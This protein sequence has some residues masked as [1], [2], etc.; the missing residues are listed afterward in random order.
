MHS[1]QTF[2]WL[3]P[4]LFALV[5][6]STADAGLIVD[7]DVDASQITPG[8]MVITVQDFTL[9]S[10][11]DSVRLRFTEGE[12]VRVQTSHAG[13]ITRSEFRIEFTATTPA[14]NQTFDL[15][16][17]FLGDTQGNSVADGAFDAM[18]EIIN[19][20][21]EAFGEFG[22][23]SEIDTTFAGI[24]FGTDPS[25]PLP[26]SSFTGGQLTLIANASNDEFGMNQG[27][28]T[29]SSVPEP[30]GAGLLG[31]FAVPLVARRRTRRAQPQSLVTSDEPS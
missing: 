15:G 6:A 20:Q 26:S 23:G 13:G 19:G 9:T 3:L 29:I 21:L 28:F 10:P 30:S 8:Q 22:G 24:R 11:M 25:T 1:E 7:V 2:L 18:V 14:G 5:S 17:S 31:L 12:Q 4:F 16:T 27:L